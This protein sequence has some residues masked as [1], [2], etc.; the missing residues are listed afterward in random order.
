M[1][2]VSIIAEKVHYVYMCFSLKDHWD[3]KITVFIMT[4]IQHLVI[5]F[6]HGLGGGG[7]MQKLSLAF[8]CSNKPFADPGKAL[9]N[10]QYQVSISRLKI[11][12]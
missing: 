8:Q 6:V 10:R 11:L 7:G 5:P 2:L 3:E 4:L 1:R 9:H 12:F